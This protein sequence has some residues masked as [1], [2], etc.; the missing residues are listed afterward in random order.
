M[1]ISHSNIFSSNPNENDKNKFE[2]D[3]EIIKNDI[4]YN[5]KI[6]LEKKELSGSIKI[7]ISFVLN[8]IFQIYEGNV[9]KTQVKENI[10]DLQL[11]QDIIHLIRNENIEII[12]QNQ[13]DIDP[14]IILKIV[15]NEESKDIK[16]FPVAAE[17]KYKLN[18][19]AKNYIS[20]EKK[21]LQLKKEMENTQIQNQVINHPMEEENNDNNSDDDDFNYIQNNNVNNIT[22]TNYQKSDE[23]HILVEINS[24]IWCM[25][26]LNKITNLENNTNIDLNLIAIGFSN[27]KII[28]I[29][30]DLLKI[31]QELK[32]PNT[33][34]S[35]TQFKDDPNYLI[36][37]LSN[38]QLIIYILK[39]D[40]FQQIQVLQ[41]PQDIKRGEINKV[42]TL[43]DGNLA[44]AERGALSIWKPKI[45]EGIKKFEF[46]KELITDEDTCQLLEVNPNVFACA[47]YRSKLINVYKND[48][49]DYPLLGKIPNAESHGNNSNGMARIND[50]IFCSG[51]KNGYIYI[52]SVFPLQVIQ[53][54]ILTEGLFYISFLHNSNDGFIFTSI[55]R[56]IIQYKI[57]LDDKNNFVKL[58]KY[59]VITDGEFNSTI[60]TTGDGKIFYSQTNDNIIYK[61]KFCLK[62]YKK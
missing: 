61:T 53:K 38:G 40:K 42:I 5:F 45:K 27:G 18:F 3:F 46:F 4:V 9:D 29:E 39:D 50:N 33:V 7:V 51:G 48:G 47:I 37:S 15:F 34:Y 41:K 19:L 60:T 14:Y 35:L 2:E 52:V 24:Q 54:I 16:L 21:Y 58:E 1:G 59:D 25:L 31:Y 6:I 36:C 17:D 32:A 23:N 62:E 26:K 10:E 49:I 57:I 28:I 13:D 56:D 44:T 12:H 11:Y 8:E 43:S 22:N 20:L 30:I 55:R